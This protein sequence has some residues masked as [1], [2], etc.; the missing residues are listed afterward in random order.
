MDLHEHK[1]VKVLK[2]IEYSFDDVASLAGVIAVL[3]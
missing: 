2:G 3:P 1:G